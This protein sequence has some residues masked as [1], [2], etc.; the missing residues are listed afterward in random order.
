MSRTIKIAFEKHSP[1]TL[2]SCW[3]GPFWIKFRIK[4]WKALNSGKRRR[5]PHVSYSVSADDA[6]KGEID[7]TNWLQFHIEGIFSET[8][9]FGLSLLPFVPHHLC[10]CLFQPC[11]YLFSSI[12]HTCRSHGKSP[13]KVKTTNVQTFLDTYFFLGKRSGC[14]FFPELGSSASKIMWVMAS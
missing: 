3:P 4:F 10:V 13:K 2:A 5:S 1:V 9:F 8:T 11:L 12:W 6:G 7:K 14:G